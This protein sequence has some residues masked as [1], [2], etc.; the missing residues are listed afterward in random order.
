MSDTKQPVGQDLPPAYEISLTPQQA[1]HLGLFT[2]IWSQIDSLME[3]CI[4]M[5]LKAPGEALATLMESYTS[6]PKLNLFWRMARGKIADD[7]TK[8]IAKKFYSGVSPLID[9]RNHIVHGVWGFRLDDEKKEKIPSC[10]Y[11]KRKDD[12][13]DA[14]ELLDLAKQAAKWSHEIYKVHCHFTGIRYNPAELHRQML[15]GKGNP[16]DKDWI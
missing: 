2:A 6:G 10:H 11:W 12:P 9:K 5:M 14:D 3:S 16:N 7:E 15:F 13:I 1:A 4:G 8:E